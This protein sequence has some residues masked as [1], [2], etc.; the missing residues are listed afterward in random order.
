M[1]ANFVKLPELLA[2]RPETLTGCSRAAG[3]HDGAAFTVGSFELPIIRTTGLL[4][5][6]I[7]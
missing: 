3:W 2:Q 7:P 1:A 6:G 4:P 5:G